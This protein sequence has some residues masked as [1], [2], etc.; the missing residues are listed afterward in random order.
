MRAGIILNETFSK[1]ALGSALR[2]VVFKH[3]CTMASM[4]HGTRFR[5]RHQRVDLSPRDSV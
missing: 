4:H 5:E 3:D 2:S 1:A